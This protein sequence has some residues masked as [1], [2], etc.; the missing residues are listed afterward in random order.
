MR[1]SATDLGGNLKDQRL[2]IQFSHSCSVMPWGATPLAERGRL[3]PLDR[4]EKLGREGRLEREGPL[5]RDGA[6][7]REAVLAPL[8][9]PFDPPLE[10]PFE[11]PSEAWAWLSESMAGAI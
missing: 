8:L 7:G 3:G 10:P 1:S 6:L 11:P 4:L 2:A 5:E 9:P